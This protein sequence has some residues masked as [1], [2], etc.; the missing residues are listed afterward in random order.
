MKI[1][2][3]SPVSLP[4]SPAPCSLPGLAYQYIGLQLWVG[5]LKLWN[6]YAL[7]WW[8][9]RTLEL[10]DSSRQQGLNWQTWIDAILWMTINVPLNFSSGGLFNAF[11]GRQVPYFILFSSLM[12][13]WCNG[14]WLIVTLCIRH[15]SIS[16][17]DLKKLHVHCQ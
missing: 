1:L 9:F 16:S 7:C 17:Q 4:W 2:Y 5:N 6:L 14:N 11:Y 10:L 15:I 12:T 3:N 8:A 13:V